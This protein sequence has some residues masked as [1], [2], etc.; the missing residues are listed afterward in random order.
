M[1]ALESFTSYET[2]KLLYQAG[3]DWNCQTHRFYSEDEYDDRCLEGIYA[4]TL[5][6]AQKWLREVKGW[7]VDVSYF[8][9]GW[10]T[11]EFPCTFYEWKIKSKSLG[12]LASI[13][14]QSQTYELALD[15]G[16]N[17]ALKQILKNE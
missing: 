7:F 9:N 2:T 3:F 16:I 10:K 14:G 4:P 8:D 5:A 17:Q 15:A 6:T 11:T 12:R 13:F 1:I